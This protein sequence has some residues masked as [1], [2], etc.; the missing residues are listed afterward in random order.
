MS[1]RM[2]SATLN[3]TSPSALAIRTILP[4]CGQRPPRTR[5]SVTGQDEERVST[6]A[7]RINGFHRLRGS[8]EAQAA[9]GSALTRKAAEEEKKDADLLT[10]LTEAMKAAVPACRQLSRFSCRFRHVNVRLMRAAVC[11]GKGTRKKNSVTH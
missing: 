5:V 4:R 8:G 6:Q 1:E 3:M 2:S 10:P 7:H 9:N 11:G